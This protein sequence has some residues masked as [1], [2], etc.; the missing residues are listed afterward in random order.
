MSAKYNHLKCKKQLINMLKYI[1][2][3]VNRPS[4]GRLEV[5]ILGSVRHNNGERSAGRAVLL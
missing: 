5:R 4:D 1:L 3:M 2:N